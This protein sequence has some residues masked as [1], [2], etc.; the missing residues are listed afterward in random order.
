MLAPIKDIRKIPFFGFL[1]YYFKILYDRSGKLIL[2]FCGIAIFS[3]LIEG[4]GFSLLLPILTFTRTSSE[5]N[6]ITNMVYNFLESIEVE[7]S[8]ISLL[9][10]LVIVFFT[11]S[12]DIIKIFLGS[13]SIYKF[14]FEMVIYLSLSFGLG[15]I[16]SRLPDKF[17]NVFKRYKEY[18]REKATILKNF[19]VN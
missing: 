4:L 9:S 14:I 18:T 19:F 16:V 13:I 8:L 1:V 17:T 12:Y 7:V 6:K 10:L 2:V 15:M 3:V 5:N 11:K